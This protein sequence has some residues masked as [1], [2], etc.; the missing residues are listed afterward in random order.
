MDI[1]LEYGCTCTDRI[2]ELRYYLSLFDK[3]G[4]DSVSLL[5][6]VELSSYLRILNNNRTV[7]YSTLIKP[8]ILKED[9]IDIALNRRKSD[10]KLRKLNGS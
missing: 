8:T 2:N 7:Y 3:G 5:K 9:E 6:I 10:N 1:K 4:I